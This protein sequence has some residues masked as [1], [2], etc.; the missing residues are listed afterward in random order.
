MDQQSLT[1]RVGLIVFEGFQRKRNLKV[2]L[3]FW[4]RLQGKMIKRSFLGTSIFF[5]TVEFRHLKPWVS[6]T[7][8]YLELEARFRAFASVKQC[9]F[10]P[11]IL[12]LGNL[13]NPLTGTKLRPPGKMFA[14]FIPSISNEH[15]REEHVTKLRKLKGDKMQKTKISLRQILFLRDVSWKH[16]VWW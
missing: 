8:R 2:R 15:W 12:N 6:R 5:T 4:R 10:T 7:S 11:D 1:R 3:S 16:P 9:H 13:E 14:H